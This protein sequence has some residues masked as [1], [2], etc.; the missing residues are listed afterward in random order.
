MMLPQKLSKLLDNWPSK[1]FSLVVAVLIYVFYHISILE[2]KNI[3]VPLSIYDNGITR[4][5]SV[6]EK[7]IHV[8]IKGLKEDIVSL[9]A[10]DFQTY[11]DINSFVTEGEFQVPVK[12][13]L[14]S[15]AS[16]VDNLEVKVSPTMVNVVLAEYATSYVPVI[17]T[18]SGSPAYG[19]ELGEV[20]V[21]PPSIKIYG[22]KNIVE[23]VEHLETEL[24][25]LNERSESFLVDV[26]LLNDNT[27]IE[28]PE[29]SNVS[30]SAELRQSMTEK[31]FNNVPVYI[32]KPSE[33]Y[34]VEE[35]EFYTKVTIRGTVLELDN[36]VIPRNTFYLDCSSI[37]EE[38]S[39]LEPVR[40]YRIRSGV[41]TNIFPSE[42]TVRIGKIVEIVPEEILLED[43]VEE[44]ESGDEIVPEELSETDNQSVEE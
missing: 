16:I 22:P 38:G 11:I 2:T 39:Y 24:I 40:N 12:V 19:Y 25:S 42:L 41:I 6:S 5:V 10:L 14:S 31:T 36:Y 13:Q 37:A 33:P 43:F 23:S 1:L 44:V 9:E 30:L 32:I 17:P 4:V 8:T 26:T 35:E 18:I 27:M 20:R 28:F 21:D 3:A 34:F 15:N 29:G 7:N